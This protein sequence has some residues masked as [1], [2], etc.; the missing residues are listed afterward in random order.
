MADMTKEKWDE[1]QKNNEELVKDIEALFTKHGVISSMLCVETKDGIVFDHDFQLP[2]LKKLG[3][4]KLTDLNTTTRQAFFV[5]N[6][7]SQNARAEHEAAQK[8]SRILRPV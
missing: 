7:L 4:V 6:V 3:M 2:L 1:L 5:N 8:K